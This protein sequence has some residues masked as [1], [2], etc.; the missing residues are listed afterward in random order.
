ME[1]QELK[2][3]INQMCGIPCDLLHGDDP[4]GIISQARQLLAFRQAGPKTTREQF[5]DILAPTN[6]DA[7]LDAIAEMV[8][9]DSRFYPDIPDNGAHDPGDGR[10][11]Y[12]RFAEIL[13][14]QLAY[15]PMKGGDVW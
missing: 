9:K 6:H 4:E 8:R 14:D 12:D 11:K 5:A 1:P 10:S 3:M 7:Q 2:Q 13:R 15:D